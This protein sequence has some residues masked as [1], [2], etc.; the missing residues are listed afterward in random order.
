M[1]APRNNAETIGRAKNNY[2]LFTHCPVW[3]NLL[4]SDLSEDGP[5]PRSAKPT[6]HVGRGFFCRKDNQCE[7]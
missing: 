7:K 5:S 2:V 6:N 3:E 1:I 4:F